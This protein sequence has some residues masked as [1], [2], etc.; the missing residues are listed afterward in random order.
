MKRFA[1]PVLA[2]AAFAAGAASMASPAGA[3]TYEPNAPGPFTGSSPDPSGDNPQIV[4]NRL[5]ASGYK[6]IL[7]KFGAAPLDQCKV[8]ST[9]PGQPIQTLVSSQGPGMN[10]NTVYTTVYLTVDCTTPVKKSH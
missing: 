5:T 1:L 6:V 4:M 2:T 7:N 9:A 3:S 8:T 10:W